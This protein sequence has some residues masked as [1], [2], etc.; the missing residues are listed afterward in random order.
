LHL[1]REAVQAVCF[2][3]GEILRIT[4]YSY[5]EAKNMPFLFPSIQRHGK[6]RE[7][8][9]DWSGQEKAVPEFENAGG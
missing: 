2:A 3:H 9:F 5:L 6:R 8:R 1:C 4:N 7:R